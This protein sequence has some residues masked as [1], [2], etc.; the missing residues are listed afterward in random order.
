MSRCCG[1]F[2]GIAS[3]PH[4]TRHDI[5]GYAPSNVAINGHR[6]LLIHAS[7]EV[8]GIT[9]YMHFDRIVKSDRDI[10]HPIGIEYFDFA[11]AF[12]G[13]SMMQIVIELANSLF[14]QIE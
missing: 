4:D 13:E 6:S 2:R 5:L 7:H 14:R 11:Y 8:T 1:A 3:H 12:A 9:A 10:V